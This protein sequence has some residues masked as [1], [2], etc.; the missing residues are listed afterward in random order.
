[1][2]LFPEFYRRY[3][4]WAIVA[5]ASEGLGQAYAH[6]LAERGLNLVTLGRR[7][8]PLERDAEL[9]RRRHRVEVRPLAVDLAAP[10][11][12]ERVA[13]ATA[14]LDIGLLVYNAALWIID[15][16]V[17][18]SLADH[19]RMIDV[20][21]RGVLALTTTIAPRLKQRGRGGIVLMS[22]MSGFQGSALLATYAATK[23]F[24]TV[25]AEGLW[26]EL[27]P[28]GVDV[29]G[30]VAGAMATPGF[31]QVTPP[32]KQAQAMPMRPEAVARGALDELERR[33]K[34][35]HLAGWAPRLGHALGALMTRRRRTVFF[36][37]M[38]HKIYGASLTRRKA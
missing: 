2:I 30:C 6:V 4:P 12:A 23:A 20:N 11:L 38:N 33:R 28:H 7:V 1:M 29:L 3:G 27:A 8:E 25:L 14:D 17:S 26:Y 21:C 34:P 31:Y 15:E 37:D 5:G 18:T 9:L 22:S 24:D 19:Q 36:S 10:D 16:F 35:T 32:E 13:A